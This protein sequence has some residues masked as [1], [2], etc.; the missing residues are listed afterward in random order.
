MAKDSTKF[1]LTALTKMEKGKASH[2]E[3]NQQQ[4][5]EQPQ[6]GFQDHS[7]QQCETYRFLV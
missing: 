2:V 4:H 6:E 7:F 5:Q 1:L 3:R